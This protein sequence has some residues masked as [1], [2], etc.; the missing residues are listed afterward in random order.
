MIPQGIC[1]VSIAL[2]YAKHCSSGETQGFEKRAVPSCYGVKPKMVTNQSCLRCNFWHPNRPRMA[3]GTG[4]KLNASINRLRNGLGN[5]F[6]LQLSPIWVPFGS[7]CG[8]C[9]PHLAPPV[10][11]RA[12]LG[13]GWAPC[14]RR[15][16]PFGPHVDPIGL[17]LGPAGLHLDPICAPLGSFGGQIKPNPSPSHPFSSCHGMSSCS[18]MSSCHD[19]SSCHDM[20]VS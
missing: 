12:P 15:W 16:S 2:H 10:P 6:W 20:S 5:D 4:Q 8:S 17:Y 9:G 11:Q 1:P 14:G 18:D 19:L 7:T 3:L 13:L